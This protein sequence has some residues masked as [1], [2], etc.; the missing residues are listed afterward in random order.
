MISVMCVD[1]PYFLAAGVPIA[2]AFVLAKN[3]PH[4]VP[5]N[6]TVMW[7]Q[8]MGEEKPIAKCTLFSKGRKVKRL[9]MLG[10][11]ANRTAIARSKW[12]SDWELEPISGLLSAIG[13]VATS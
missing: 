13:R 3:L 2:Q 5:L 6:P 10:T 1:P 9:G 11:G 7:I 8:I 4:T 12:P